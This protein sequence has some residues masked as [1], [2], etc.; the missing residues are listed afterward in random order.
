MTMGERRRRLDLL[1]AAYAEGE[2][3]IDLR[4]DV[5]RY[6]VDR[7]EALAQFTA[8][9]PDVATRPELNAHAAKCRR[10]RDWVRAHA[11]VLS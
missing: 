1:C 6:V 4:G 3:E 9:R 8:N 5:L 2:T 10:D 11:T 7:L